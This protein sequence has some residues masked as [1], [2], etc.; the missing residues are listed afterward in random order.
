M[1]PRIKYYIIIFMDTNDIVQI[2]RKSWHGKPWHGK[3]FY[4]LDAYCKNTYG[5]KVYKIALKGGYTCPNRDGTLGRRGCLFCSEGG[6]GDFASADI[7]QGLAL[8]SGK[9]TGHKYIAYFQSY[10]GTYGSLSYLEALYRNALAEDAVV[11]ISIATRPDCLGEPVLNL[12]KQLKEEYPLKFIWMELGLQTIHET[13]ATHIRRGYSLLVFEKAVT[14]LAALQIPVICHLI[15]GLPGETR[16]MMMASAAYLNTRTVWGVKLQLLHVLEGT[17]LAAE[18]RAG[19]YTPLTFEE[20][21]DI[22][23]PCIEILSQAGTVIHRVTG[24]APKDLLIAP[25]WSLNKKKVLNAITAA[26][27]GW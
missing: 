2:H 25:M 7:E 19:Q 16:E 3:P 15:L 14:D 6:S 1:H 8:L 20:Y 17:D 11:G 13:T 5:E 10:T 27:Q 21:L 9:K 18:Y 4:S 22:V 26:L 24:D 12:L 23:V